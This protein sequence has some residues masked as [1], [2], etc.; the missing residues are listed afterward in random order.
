MAYMLLICTDSE[1]SN[2]QMDNLKNMYVYVISY[3]ST[4]SFSFLHVLTKFYVKW[5]TVHLETHTQKQ[6]LLNC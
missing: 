1:M 5:S 3:K 2:N 6:M 4:R